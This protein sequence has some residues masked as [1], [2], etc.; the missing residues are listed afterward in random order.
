MQDLIPRP[1]DHNLSQ[2]ETLQQLSHPGVPQ[3]LPFDFSFH[4]CPQ[5]LSQKAPVG[6][7]PA[8]DADC[9]YSNSAVRNWGKSHRRTHSE[10]DTDW[11]PFLTSRPQWHSVSPGKE[12]RRFA[13]YT[14]VMCTPPHFS[15]EGCELV[16][17]LGLGMR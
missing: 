1:W 7:F 16:G 15:L 5:P 4:N 3:G 14:G 13:V 12:G 11:S 10:R 8:A 9:V 6:I 2:R 17:W